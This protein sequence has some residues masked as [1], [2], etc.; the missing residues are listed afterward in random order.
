MITFIVTTY[1]LEDY[2]LQRCLTSIVM[3]G[4]DDYEIIVVDDES[5]ISPQHVIDEFT[6]QANIRLLTQRH[7]RQGAARNLALSHAKGNW[8]QFVDGDDY[9]YPNTIQP[10]LELAEANKLDLLMFGYREVHDECTNESTLNEN[11][12][13]CTPQLQLSIITGNEYMLYHNLFGS[14][15]TLLFQ[16]TLLDAPKYGVPLRFAENIY[17]EDEEFVT[18]LVWRAQRMSKT[19]SIVYAYYQRPGSTTR[20][21]SR[22]HQRELTDNYFIV[23][24]RLIDFESTLNDHPH[25][26]VTRKVRFLSID[27]LRR[28]LKSSDWEQ[29]WTYASERLKQVGLFPLPQDKYTYKYAI[30]R[31]MSQSALGAKILRLVERLM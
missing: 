30:F 16:R 31:M 11:N 5:E 18:Q 1:N 26:G 8:I 9:L 6:S 23:L 4:I 21:N 22:T 28:A 20:N 24:Q 13:K 10:C 3:Q 15:C 29:Q 12:T 17:I 7:S 27:I 19:D 14:C 25:D 2:L